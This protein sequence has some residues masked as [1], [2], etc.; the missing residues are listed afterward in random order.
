MEYYVVICVFQRI[1][2][3]FH[4]LWWHMIFTALHY[5]SHMFAYI[6]FLQLIAFH[7]QSHSHS[8][9]ISIFVCIIVYLRVCVC[10]S[11]YSFYSILLPLGMLLLLR[12]VLLLQATYAYHNTI[13]IVFQCLYN[14][15]YT[16]Y[17]GISQ[18]VI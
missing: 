7:F 6:A 3:S 12:L 13:S 16:S 18:Y 14:T 10:V 4:L 17:D 11:T 8:H 15:H 9:S 2:V 5:V 1:S